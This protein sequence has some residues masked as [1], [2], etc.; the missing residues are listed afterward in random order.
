MGMGA[1]VCDI[2]E[3]IASA[4]IVVRPS[5]RRFSDRSNLV[6]LGLGSVVTSEG[7]L[8]EYPCNVTSG[9]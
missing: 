5:V 1:V 6:S 9:N 7:F 3:I 8:T 2:R 4:G